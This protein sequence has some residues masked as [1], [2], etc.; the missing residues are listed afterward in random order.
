MNSYPRGHVRS[1]L[2]NPNPEHA[3]IY[4]TTESADLDA[5]MFNLDATTSDLV[6]KQEYDGCHEDAPSRVGIWFVR[7]IRRPNKAERVIWTR[8]GWLH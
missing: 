6:A 2:I 5:Q 7:E 3:R 4:E 1:T 8:I